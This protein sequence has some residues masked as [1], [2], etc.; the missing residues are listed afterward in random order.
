M[1]TPVVTLFL[2]ALSRSAAAAIELL[3]TAFGGIVVSD[4]FSA[5]N[6]LPTQQRQLCWAHVIR[7][8]TAISERPGATAELGMELLDLPQQL[9]APMVPLQK[10]HDR[11]IQVGAELLA[12]PQS[13]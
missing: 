7:D 9:F 13:V 6:N 3:G 4:C 12:D 11:L 1:V 8:L 5:H 10:R 2:Q